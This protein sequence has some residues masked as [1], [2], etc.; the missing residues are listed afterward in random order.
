MVAGRYC[1]AARPIVHPEEEDYQ[2]RRDDYEADYLGDAL[3]CTLARRR[4]LVLLWTE[5]RCR[6]SNVECGKCLVEKAKF[7]I[8][9][10]AI[11]KCEVG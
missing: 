9:K 11:A 3:T 1:K 5:C 7:P 2:Y 4:H 10:M 6:T 8:P